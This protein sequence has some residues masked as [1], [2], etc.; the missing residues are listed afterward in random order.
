[1]RRIFTFAIV[2]ALALAVGMGGAIAETNESIDD[3]DELEDA[4]GTPIDED[5][6]L[7]D[8]SEDDGTFSLTFENDRDRPKTITLTESTQPDE[9]AQ[10]MAIRQ[11]RLLSGETTISITTQ[12]RGGAAAV[13]VTTSDSIAN[14][15]GTVISTGEQDSGDDP[16]APFGGTS[17]VF[18]GVGLSIVMSAGAAGWVLWREESGVIKA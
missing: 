1:M 15:Q 9:G 2:V 13:S 18:S 3:Q 4:G 7:V 17:G 8:W 16:F 12:V 10:S 6:T 11:E 5:V 14:G